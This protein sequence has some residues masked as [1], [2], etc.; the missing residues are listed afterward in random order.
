MAQPRRAVRRI[1]VALHLIYAE[2]F[3]PSRFQ[4][5][6]LGTTMLSET[7][8]AK[9][10]S[11]AGAAGD[12]GGGF[13]SSSAF[14]APASPTYDSFAASA[15]ASEAGR[16]RF[17]PMPRGVP[18]DSGASGS[19]SSS[20]GSFSWAAHAAK[21]AK[22]E[23]NGVPGSG[24]GSGSG[25][26]GGGSGSQGSG[27]GS[28]AAAQGLGLVGQQRSKAMDTSAGEEEIDIM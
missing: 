27:A 11:S 5:D 2:P 14:N 20:A 15:A 13:A 18:M 22:L 7:D 6:D 10:E 12:D 26:G 24:S 3:A 21:R 28:A 25:G 1:Y 17:A 4:E 23:H 19:G 8:I 9:L 16:D